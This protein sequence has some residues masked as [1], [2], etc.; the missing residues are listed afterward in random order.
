[1]RILV[2]VCIS[3]AALSFSAVQVQELMYKAD[4]KAAYCQTAP[5]MEVCK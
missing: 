5:Y 2:Y 4:H 3:I 1:M